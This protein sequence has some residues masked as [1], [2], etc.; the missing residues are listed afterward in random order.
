MSNF[1]AILVSKC[2]IMEQDKK[3]T[4]AERMN[5]MFR[6]AIANHLAS[7]KSDFAAL[8]DIAPQT[9]SRYLSGRNEP[10]TNTWRA[11]NVKLGKPFH[12]DWLITGR[13]EMFKNL[14]S[15]NEQ[16]LGDA[17]I[18]DAIVMLIQEM[19]ESRISRDEQ[20]NRI[21]TLM[22]NLQKK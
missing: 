6:F 5:E 9:L 21:L 2:C 12:D 1:N 4:P 3:K 17:P 20:M 15:A 11:F 16:P 10:P 14:T 13:G 18:T 8:L 22:E 19:R 7:S